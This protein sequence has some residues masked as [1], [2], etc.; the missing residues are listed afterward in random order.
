MPVRV[1]IV[2][3]DVLKPNFGELVC[4]VQNVSVWSGGNTLPCKREVWFDFGLMFHAD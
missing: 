3:S 4:V 2:L 1:I